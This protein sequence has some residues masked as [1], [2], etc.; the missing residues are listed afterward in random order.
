MKSFLISLA[1]FAILDTLWLGVVMAKFNYEQLKH[2]GRVTNGRFDLIY[3]PLPIIYLLMAALMAFFVAP[4]ISGT[5]SYALCFLMGAL[6]GLGVYG[7]FDM[8][9]YA[10]LKDYPL[11]FGFVDMA[12][13]SCLFGITAVILR[14]SH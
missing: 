5:D 10:I 7:V 12:W 14:L 2:I 11:L 8:T 13:G 6:M 3:W 1:S 4:K 9:N